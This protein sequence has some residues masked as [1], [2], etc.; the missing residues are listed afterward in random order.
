MIDDCFKPAHDQVANKLYCL[1]NELTCL[2]KINQFHCPAF[3][4]I[5]FPWFYNYNFSIPAI[6]HPSSLEIPTETL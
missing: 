6:P 5:S 2:P 3:D 4:C 1:V